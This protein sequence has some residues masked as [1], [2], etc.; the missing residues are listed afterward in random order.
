MTGEF[1]KFLEVE[2]L[3]TYLSEIALVEASQKNKHKIWYH[4]ESSVV[5]Y[6]MNK[7]LVENC[8]I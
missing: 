1:Y 6:S 5:L 2:F 4:L 3:T 8:F 7:K